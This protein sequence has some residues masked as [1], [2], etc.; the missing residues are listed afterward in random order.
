M[1]QSFITCKK[2][3]ERNLNSK[4]NSKLLTV[5]LFDNSGHVLSGL[6][7]QKSLLL[8]HLVKL[9]IQISRNLSGNPVKLHIRAREACHQ[10]QNIPL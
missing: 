6:Q 1:S 3:P 2:T 8:A 7:H 5:R 10:P 4:L 9:N